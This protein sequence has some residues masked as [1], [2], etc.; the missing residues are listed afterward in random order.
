MIPSILVYIFI[1]QQIQVWHLFICIL[2]VQSAS[3]KSNTLSQEAST[4]SST[5][6]PNH[7]ISNTATSSDSVVDD[8]VTVIP[9]NSLKKVQ[10]WTD[11]IKYI[12]DDR[13]KQRLYFEL[14]GDKFVCVGI[15]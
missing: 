11:A 8:L 12:C 3:L 4:S 6:Y 13:R 9:T 7:E 10:N 15:F 1:C 2:L 14:F 5:S